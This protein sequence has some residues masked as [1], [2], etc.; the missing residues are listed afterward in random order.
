L[1]E[2]AW[3]K[4]QDR[5]PPVRLMSAAAA[6]QVTLFLADPMARLPS[7]PRM[8]PAEFDFPVALKTGTSQDYRD[9]WTIAYTADT[10]VGVWVGRP[11][12]DA[13]RGLG[14]MSTAARL[15]HDVI[16]AVAR[17]SVRPREDLSFPPPEGHR[18]VEVCGGDGGAC[19][20]IFREWVPE[21]AATDD[22]G[23]VLI[24]RRSSSVADQSTPESEIVEQPLPSS[25]RRAT[26]VETRA[27]SGSETVRLSIVAPENN[28]RILRDPDAPPDAD[29]LTLRAA[30]KGPFKTIVWY[31]DG[32]PYRTAG[33]QE[34]VQWK[35]EPGMHR[36]QIGLPGRPESSAVT[37]ITVE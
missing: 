30:V 10:L 16:M 36:L 7:F 26:W 32:T 21:D 25:L 23:H 19:A 3:Y 13:M 33:A 4:G 8:G 9:A 34:S 15:A 29:T 35:L 14:G 6:R 1:G 37:S 27:P 20:P 28:I 5:P 31:V 18:A 2:L 17:R 12:S 11:D 22:V 24:D